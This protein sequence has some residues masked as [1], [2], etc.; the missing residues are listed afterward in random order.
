MRLGCRCMVVIQK[1]ASRKQ[2]SQG[3]GKSPRTLVSLYSIS[4]LKR[5]VKHY[6]VNE[7]LVAGVLFGVPKKIKALIHAHESCLG[8]RNI[9]LL[10]Q[11][12][13]YDTGSRIY[14]ELHWSMF[15]PKRIVLRLPQIRTV[16]IAWK[17]QDDKY[18]SPHFH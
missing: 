7:S 6:T 3:T 8:G 13:K 10:E 18:Q 14:D 12:T 4:K 9:F 5:Y 1:E 15:N 17:L 11:H 16:S 2:H